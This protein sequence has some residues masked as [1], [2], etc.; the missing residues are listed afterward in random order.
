MTILVSQTNPVEVKTFLYVRPFLFLRNNFAYLHTRWAQGTSKEVEKCSKFSNRSQQLG[1]M[2]NC[3][4][5]R[6]GIIWIESLFWT[7]LLN[8]RYFKNVSCELNR[9]KAVTIVSIFPDAPRIAS[10][11]SYGINPS[12]SLVIESSSSAITTEPRCPQG[13]DC[14]GKLTNVFSMKPIFGRCGQ[15][16][17]DSMVYLLGNGIFAWKWDRSGNSELENGVHGYPK[18]KMLNFW[19]KLNERNVR[20]RKSYSSMNVI[21][22]LRSVRK[23]RN[24]VKF[25]KN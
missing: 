13:F 6:N 5:S 20:I 22:F 7:D 3:E 17:I 15:Y 21:Y 8:E 16:T 23:K 14:N 2:R 19:L 4:Q 11:I 18:L 9:E 24:R 12:P 25:S 1:K 10:T